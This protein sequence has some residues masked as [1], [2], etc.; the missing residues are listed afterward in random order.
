MQGIYR[1]RL[2]TVAKVAW[3]KMFSAKNTPGRVPGDLAACGRFFYLLSLKLIY[4]IPL[5]G[6]PVR[7]QKRVLWPDGVDSQEL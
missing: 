2:H 5:R 3:L 7:P 4:A 6:N 1:L